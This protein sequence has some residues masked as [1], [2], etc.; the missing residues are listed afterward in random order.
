MEWEIEDI[1]IH[2]HIKVKDTE[3]MI[4]IG[5]PHSLA[6][7]IVKRHNDAIRKMENSSP[8]YF[9]EKCGRSLKRNFFDCDICHIGRQID[10]EKEFKHL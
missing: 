2:A 6:L 10:A 7:N 1:G 9:C 4:G 5:L 3:E 8:S